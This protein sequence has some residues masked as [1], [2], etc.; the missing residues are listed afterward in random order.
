MKIG[1]YGLAGFG[2][3]AA[4]E[5]FSKK[6]AAAPTTVPPISTD[7]A[8]SSFTGT[9]WQQAG[10]NRET[11]W[12]DGGVFS[13][14]AGGGRY[15]PTGIESSKRGDND[16]FWMSYAR[17]GMRLRPTD[18]I[19]QDGRTLRKG[20][21]NRNIP[22]SAPLFIGRNGET[23]MN[24]NTPISAPMFGSPGPYR[25]ACGDYSNANG[26]RPGARRANLQG[27]DWQ[28]TNMS[29]ACGSCAG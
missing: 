24:R 18:V 6:G 29:N 7:E 9:N 4:Y 17:S 22:I 2:A 1:L 14:A 26:A 23:V 5:H 27:T 13:N 16:P 10:R 20:M 19:S 21:P 8:T 15:L 28:T 12:Q 11:M 3:Y 25:N